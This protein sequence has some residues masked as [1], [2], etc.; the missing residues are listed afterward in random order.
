MFGDLLDASQVS[1]SASTDAAGSQQQTL[2]TSSLPPLNTADA[3][4]ARIAHGRSYMRCDELC[5]SE[6]TTRPLEPLKPSPA[7]YPV[8]KSSS[9]QRPTGSTRAAPRV[10]EAVE[11]PGSVGSKRI[12]PAPFAALGASAGTADTA[13]PGS[14]DQVV[15]PAPSAQAAISVPLS[16]TTTSAPVTDSRRSTPI[17]DGT[18][19]ASLSEPIS[20]A[21]LAALARHLAHFTSSNPTPGHLAASVLGDLEAC[22][23]EWRSPTAAVAAPSSSPRKSVIERLCFMH[24]PTAVTALLA[25]A[26]STAPLRI[27]VVPMGGPAVSVNPSDLSLAV[28]DVLPAAATT[29]RDMAL[30]GLARLPRTVTEKTASVERRTVPFSL[31]R[32]FFYVGEPL[33]LEPRGSEDAGNLRRLIDA[34]VSAAAGR[35]VSCHHE[36][37]LDLQLCDAGGALVSGTLEDTVLLPRLAG[38]AAPAVYASLQAVVDSAASGTFKGRTLIVWTANGTEVRAD[39]TDALDA[40]GWMNRPWHCAQ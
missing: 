16:D 13:A 11:Q 35:T 33:L 39:G 1:E 25:A 20:P 10:D 37:L 18:T 28:A 14:L 32:P 27:L 30:C 40:R 12:S 8:P 4:A 17:C 23:F 38:G 21:A 36:D 5:L 19:A 29:G 3:I 26:D 15:T 31:P 6:S 22:G 2:D 24:S 34:A 7:W 9:S